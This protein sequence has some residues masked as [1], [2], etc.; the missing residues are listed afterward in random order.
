MTLITEVVSKKSLDFRNQ[1]KAYLLRTVH[2]RPYK[3]IAQVVV[4]GQGQHPCWATVRNICETFSGRKGRRPYNYHKCGRK[5][6]KLTRPVQRFVLRKLIGQRVKQVVT[7]PSLAEAVAR[8]KGVILE[9]SSIRKFLQRRGYRWLPRSQKRKYTEEDRLRRMA[10]ARSVLRLS[11]DALRLKLAMSL[12]GV[13]LSMPPTSDV[14]RFNYCW[15]GISHMWRKPGEANSPSLAGNDGYD[16][17]L[18]VSRAIPLWGGCSAHGFETVLWHAKKKTDHEEWSAAVRQGK[19]T[20]ALRRLNPGRRHRP[21]TVLC[22][23]ESFLR[24]PAPMRAY[25]QKRVRLWAVPP[26]SP[27]LN[28]IEMFWGWVRR[29]LRLQ[30]LDDLR[31]H[32][33]PLTKAAYILRIE[34]LFRS[35]KA[36]EVAGK[37]AMKLRSKCRDVLASSGAAI[38]S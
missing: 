27:D 23:N 35:A 30:D 3:S 20:A 28:P 16:K 15:G 4:N 31:H 18:P 38:A 7:S 1:Q 6:W 14:D 19:L 36:Q 11:E 37:C 12:D 24:H 2:K 22:D 26:R 10:F 32:R 17:Q 5:A 29:Q 8:E 21:W 33:A 34:A 25:V 9:A 13:V